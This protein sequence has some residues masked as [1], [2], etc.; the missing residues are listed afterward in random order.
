[1]SV[2]TWENADNSHST[3]WF[4]PA[5]GRAAIFKGMAV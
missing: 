3:R 1:M 5:D 4:A 2:T